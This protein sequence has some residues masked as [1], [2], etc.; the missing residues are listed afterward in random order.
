MLVWY[1]YI[2]WY[3]CH[4]SFYHHS[5]ILLSMFI[6]LGIRCPWLTYHIPLQMV[7]DSHWQ[8]QAS[9][10]PAWEPQRAERA[11]FPPSR[12]ACCSWCCP[13]SGHTLPEHSQRLGRGKLSCRHLKANVSEWGGMVSRRKMEGWDAGKWEGMLGR[14]NNSFLRQCAWASRQ[15]A[16]KQLFVFIQYYLNHLQA[17]EMCRVIDKGKTWGLNIE[18]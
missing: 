9:A 15:N 3:D 2:L 12:Q 16:E 5:T 4:W 10:L 6:T 8:L 14:L 7:R 13:G 11:P 17:T 18:I 1:V